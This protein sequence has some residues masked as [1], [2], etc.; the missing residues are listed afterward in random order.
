M[1]L[2]T[3]CRQVHELRE[4][5]RVLGPELRAWINPVA[6]SPRDNPEEVR[7]TR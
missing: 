1:M 7:E 3:G 2:L 4:V 6:P 5:P